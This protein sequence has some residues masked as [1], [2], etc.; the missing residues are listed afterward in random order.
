MDWHDGFWKWKLNKIKKKK[1]N[2][3]ELFTVG[4]FDAFEFYANQ[5]YHYLYNNMYLS[6]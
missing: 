2:N 4:L 6:Q 3:P 5:L 1:S